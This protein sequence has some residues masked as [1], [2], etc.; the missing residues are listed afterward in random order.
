MTEKIQKVLAAAGFGSRRQIEGWIQ[1][2]RIIVDGKVAKINP[3][4]QHAEHHD[5]DADRADK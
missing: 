2:G 4:N 3:A 1:E 5:K